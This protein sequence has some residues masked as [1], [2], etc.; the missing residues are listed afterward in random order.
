MAP[1]VETVFDTL[2]PGDSLLHT[3]S[4]PVDLTQDGSYSFDF[5]TNFTQR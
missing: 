2:H 4:L 3:F 1:T 5:T